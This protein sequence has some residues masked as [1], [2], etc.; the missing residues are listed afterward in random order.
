M[1]A[2]TADYLTWQDHAACRYADPELFF[3]EGDPSL[4][5]VAA[6]IEAAKQV[7]RVCP[8]RAACLEWA[9]GASDKHSVAGG[10]TPDERRL[11]RRR[12]RRSAA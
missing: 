8:V 3:P 10:T 11:Q 9:M 1:T 12:D 5:A 6:Q 2:V 4:P 7:C